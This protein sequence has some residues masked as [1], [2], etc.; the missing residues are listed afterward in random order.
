MGNEQQ[1]TGRDERVPVKLVVDISDA[2][3][4]KNHADTLITYSLGSCIG[5]SLYDPATKIGGMLHFQLPSAKQSREG[6]I[7]PMMFADT[8]TDELLRQ[9]SRFGA[10]TK[11]LQVKVAGGAQMLNDTKMFNIGKR[12]YAAVRQILWKK[13]MFIS[14]Q[15]VGGKNARTMLLRLADGEVALKVKGQVKIL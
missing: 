15:D 4:S 8:G 9:L 14:G 7:N 3:V 5:L 12:N 10:N 1:Y 6:N 2:K 13:G 11:R